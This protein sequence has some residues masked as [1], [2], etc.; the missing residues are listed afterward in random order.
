[1]K[2]ES[3]ERSYPIWLL[4]N[5]KHP[6]VLRS[7]WTPILDEIQDK[8]YRKIETRIDTTNIFI[9]NTIDDSG[10]VPNTLNWW[11][12]E[13]AKEIELFRESILEYKPKI[14]I[15]FGAFPFEFVRRIFNIKPEKGPKYW[16]NSNLNSEFERAIENFDINQ[17][18]RIPILR[19]VSV[20]S[21][22]EEDHRLSNLTD[23]SNYFRNV[24]AKIADKIIENKDSLNIW[25]E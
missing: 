24:G 17:T 1:M 14:L 19:Q 11:A 18:N 15:S 5:P 6:V 3:G 20:S 9:R 13:V 8:V 25:I 23:I 22:F 2:N 21:K 7:I 10:K 16:S 12:A 4:L